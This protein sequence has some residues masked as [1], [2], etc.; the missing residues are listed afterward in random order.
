MSNPK[1]PSAHSHPIVTLIISTNESVAS[2]ARRKQACQARPKFQRRVKVQFWPLG[3][4]STL[5]HGTRY[6]RRMI[7]PF[8]STSPRPKSTRGTLCQIQIICLGY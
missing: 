3:K 6:P 8:S 7:L 1:M 2:T 4:I 5:L